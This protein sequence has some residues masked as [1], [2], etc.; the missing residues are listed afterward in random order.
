MKQNYVALKEQ[1]KTGKSD[2]NC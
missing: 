2:R 1:L